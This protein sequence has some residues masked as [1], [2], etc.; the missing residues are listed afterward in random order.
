MTSDSP[1]LDGSYAAFGK[2]L[3]GMENA[4]RIVNTPRDG[5]DKPLTPQVIQ[6]IRVETFD[7]VYPFEQ[8]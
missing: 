6:S 2:V 7:K 1:H 5:S 3:E 8:M 4:D